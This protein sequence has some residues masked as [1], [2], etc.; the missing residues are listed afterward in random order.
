MGFDVRM[1]VL[2]PVTQDGL[3]WLFRHDAIR[4]GA[5]SNL[6]PVARRVKPTK[7]WAAYSEEVEDCLSAARFVGK[8]LANSGPPHNAFALMGVKP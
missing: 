8:W 4:T 3:L 1:R 5:N 6:L 7:E 2:V